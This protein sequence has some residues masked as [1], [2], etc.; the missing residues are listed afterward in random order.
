MFSAALEPGTDR[1][2][3]QTNQRPTYASQQ[4]SHRHTL[5]P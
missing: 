3:H 2:A 4:G 5:A 1:D